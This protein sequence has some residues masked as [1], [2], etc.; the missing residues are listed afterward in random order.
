MTYSK[1]NGSK[2]WVMILAPI[3]REF[4]PPDMVPDNDNADDD[5]DDSDAE[6]AYETAPTEPTEDEDD[7]T[8]AVE[9]H[10]LKMY[11]QKKGR[12][13]ALSKT[14]DGGMENVSSSVRIVHSQYSCS[15]MAFLIIND[16]KIIQS[17]FQSINDAVS[18]SL[19]TGTTEVKLRWY[20]K[21]EK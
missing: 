2:K 12:C 3:W 9:G 7:E 1:A 13:S 20:S 14:T 8:A 10:G 21:I 5:E 15:R 4:Q 16:Y 6:T 19:A 17:D 11:L 18:S